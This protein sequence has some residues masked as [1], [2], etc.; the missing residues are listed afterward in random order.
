VV[1]SSSLEIFE[2]DLSGVDPSQVEAEDLNLLV[3][4]ASIEDEISFIERSS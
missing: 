1:S 2:C 3:G 4:G